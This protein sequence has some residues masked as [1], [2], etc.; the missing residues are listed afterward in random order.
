M[1]RQKKIKSKE[2]VKVG[3]LGFGK[4]RKKNEPII[5]PNGIKYLRCKECEKLKKLE[6]D[7]A[8][9]N[10]MSHKRKNYCKVCISNNIKKS[11]IKKI[12]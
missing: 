9:D 4:G 2:I 5:A 10:A 12:S 8:V 1:R 3:K 7:F 6:E 11:K